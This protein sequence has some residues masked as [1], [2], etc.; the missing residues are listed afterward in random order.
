MSSAALDMSARDAAFATGKSK[1]RGKS[2]ERRERK[3]LTIFDIDRARTARKI[4]RE[5]LCR[6]AN[7]HAATYREALAGA[8]T[9]RRILIK[10][11][12]ALGLIE[13]PR[14][15]IVRGLYRAA[16]T[17]FAGE[18]GADVALALGPV[19]RLRNFEIGNVLAGR[20]RR[21][22]FYLTCNAFE[23]ERREISDIVGYSKQAASKALKEI[24]D[25]R[26][27][28]H[29]LNMLVNRVAKLLTGSELI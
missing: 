15:E 9:Q 26:E 18:L 8:A 10:L 12:R 11:S 7:V 27:A 13:S 25:Q 23:I 28:D 14:P 2:T 22:A 16:V 29:A 5:A 4:S 19:Q 17:V 3:T 21:A 24:E 20:A 1:P 6:R